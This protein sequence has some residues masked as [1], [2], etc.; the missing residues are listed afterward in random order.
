MDI[1]ESLLNFSIKNESFSQTGFGRMK[2]FEIHMEAATMNH[3]GI[4]GGGWRFHSEFTD[5]KIEDR[6][7]LLVGGTQIL[8]P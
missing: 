2:Y 8:V 6:G 5:G 4:S 3:F 1:L 7:C